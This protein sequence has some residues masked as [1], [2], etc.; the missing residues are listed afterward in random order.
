[1]AGPLQGA[2]LPVLPSYVTTRAA[3]KKFHPD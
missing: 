2:Q 1:M 3:W